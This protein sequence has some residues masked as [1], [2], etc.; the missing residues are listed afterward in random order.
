MRFSDFVILGNASRRDFDD[1]NLFGN[2][3]KGT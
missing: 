3:F 1:D 2:L